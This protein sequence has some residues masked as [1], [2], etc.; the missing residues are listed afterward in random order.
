MI[1]AL[2]RY[3]PLFLSLVGL[4]L[5]LVALAQGA[6][7][8]P[9]PST[10]PLPPELAYLLTTLGPTGAW[11]YLAWLLG[12]GIPVR[13]PEEGARVRLA[14]DDHDLLRRGTSA[15]EQLA[16]RVPAPAA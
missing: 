13:L 11:V 15:A 9:P 4:L 16:A 3:L 1:T 6:T 12:K 14:E 2:R 8:S 5:P 7:D 10:T